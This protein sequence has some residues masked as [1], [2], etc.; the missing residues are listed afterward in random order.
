MAP[1]SRRVAGWHFHREIV[2]ASGP[3]G[4]KLGSVEMLKRKSR[5]RGGADKDSDN[6][7]SA[8]C[9]EPHRR[10]VSREGVIYGC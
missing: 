4:F 1:K 8:A 6:V 10:I 7:F 2:V 3:P 5:L 9:E